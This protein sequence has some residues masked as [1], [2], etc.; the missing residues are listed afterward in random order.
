MKRLTPWIMWA[1]ALG[2]LAGATQELRL[3][4]ELAAENDTL[5]QLPHLSLTSKPLALADYQ[6][7]QKKTPV[8]G[9]VEVKAS[10]N[11]ITVQAGILSDYAAWRLIVDQVLLD[12]PGVTWRIDSLC[13]GK[14]STAEAHKAELSG[15]RQTVSTQKGTTGTAP[16]EI[17]PV[18]PVTPKVSTQTAV[19]NLTSLKGT[20][21][22]H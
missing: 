3:Q 17:K 11:T 20:D 19:N 6:A 9:T 13:S 16:S 12:N 8:S 10:A 22:Q 15:V 7:I 1:V 14:C 18:A 5:A 21:N 2:A 4:R